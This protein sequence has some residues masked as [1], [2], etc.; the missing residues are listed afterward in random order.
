MHSAAKIELLQGTLD[1]LILKVLNGGPLEQWLQDAR[2][3][4]RA[5]RKNLGFTA[6][7]VLTLALGI[8][9]NTVAFSFY[10][11][12]VGKPLPVRAPR[13]ILRVSADGHRFEA[14]FSHDEYGDLGARL[15]SV[16]AV[17]ATSPLQVLLSSASADDHEQP[18]AVQLVSENYFS[19]LGVPAVLGRTFDAGAG[20]EAVLSFDAWQRRF[21]GAPDVLGRALH[22]QGLSVTI[23]G[24]APPS[25]GGTPP[26]GAR[27]LAANG[28]T[29]AA[30]AECR[31][32]ARSGHP[33]VA[34]A[35]AAPTRIRP[36]A[37]RR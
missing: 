27:F 18:A 20:D 13:E 15:Q 36:C 29:T 7:V 30:A 8:G 34:V 28:R 11:T 24:V 22:L 33:R 19:A 37:G 25:F 12:L 31:L 6:V 21:H 16:V 3:A 5:L 17:I 2:Y 9:L 10:H 35:G 32:A 14:P 4:A 26:F 1:L 23:V